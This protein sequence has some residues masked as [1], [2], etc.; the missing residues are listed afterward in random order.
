[1]FLRNVNPV[2]DVELPLLARVLARGEVF[3]V[4]DETGALLLEQVGNYET[5][6]APAPAATDA[7]EG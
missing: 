4:D 6:D 2:G 3:E 1:M 7:Q 5:A